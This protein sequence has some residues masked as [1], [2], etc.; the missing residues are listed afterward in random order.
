MPKQKLASH[1]VDDVI[2]FDI[3]TSYCIA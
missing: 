2:Y 3:I 1:P